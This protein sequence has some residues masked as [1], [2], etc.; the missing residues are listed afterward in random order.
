MLV[1]VSS[2]H[3]ERRSNSRSRRARREFTSSQAQNI[4]RSGNILHGLSV[5]RSAQSHD[6]RA[7]WCTC[8]RPNPQF[9]NELSAAPFCFLQKGETVGYRA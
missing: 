6:S 2:G 3:F 4:T 7:G 1:L 8:E 9:G 5:L